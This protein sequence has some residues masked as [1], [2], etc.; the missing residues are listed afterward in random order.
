MAPGILI[1]PS[2]AAAPLSPSSIPQRPVTAVE[3]YQ[4]VQT[5]TLVL[6]DG[7]SFQ[8]ISFG[9]EGKSI[10]GECVFQTGKPF[11]LINYESLALIFCVYAWVINSAL[12]PQA[13]LATRNR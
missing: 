7:S 10:S 3:D 4:H 1:S 13:W 5:A 2:A 12:P 9:A 8:G 11:L 6:E